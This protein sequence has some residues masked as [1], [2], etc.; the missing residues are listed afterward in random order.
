ML[1]STLICL[2][3]KW[4]VARDPNGSYTQYQPFWNLGCT[5][6]RHIGNPFR[7]R[8][9]SSFWIQDNSDWRWCLKL[10][11]LCFFHMPYL[12]SFN[13]HLTSEYIWKNG[14]TQ[15]SPGQPLSWAQLSLGKDMKLP[16]RPRRWWMFQG[17]GKHLGPWAPGSRAALQPGPLGTSF[18][19]DFPPEPACFP[20][21]TAS[22]L[23]GVLLPITADGPA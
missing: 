8:Q 2:P 7:F 21:L 18:L 3:G 22:H 1:I 11:Q 23:G 19:L 17:K 6:G 9:S 13:K 15:R 4:W 20:G 10:P 16:K 5:S 14:T 12:A